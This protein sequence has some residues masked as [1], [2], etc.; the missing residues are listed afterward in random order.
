MLL[1][2]VLEALGAS[3]A[4]YTVPSES[5]TAHP[6]PRADPPQLL[7]QRPLLDH[8]QRRPSMEQQ[9]IPDR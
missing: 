1:S 9:R 5:A 2:S 7:P 4:L 6:L 8:Q 3:P